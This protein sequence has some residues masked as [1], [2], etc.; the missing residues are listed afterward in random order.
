MIIS[1]TMLTWL[2]LYLSRLR[3]TRNW[4]DAAC[5][6][7]WGGLIALQLTQVTYFIILAGIAYAAGSIVVTR[8]GRAGLAVR[9]A[10]V[11]VL[12]ALVSSP[13][14]LSRWPTC[15]IP[16]ARDLNWAMP[17]LARWTSG[18]C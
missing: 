9:F 14:W 18:H 4:R 6:G 1:A 11:G 13:Q 17:L 16:I 3:R 2:W 15:L 8:P 5:A 10:G 12:A 7:I